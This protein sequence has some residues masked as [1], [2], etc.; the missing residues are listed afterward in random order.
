MDSTKKEKNSFKK[1][2]WLFS[3]GA[4]GHDMVY[5][6]V[7]SYLLTYIQFGFRLS[8]PQYLI[9]SFA[10]GVLGRIWDAI[11]D[12][13]MGWLI[14]KCNF[15]SGKYRFWILLGAVLTGML[16]VFLFNANFEGWTFVIYIVAMNLLW[17]TAY[18]IND[19]SY[20][21]M[22][23]S[24][25]SDSKERNIISTLTL[26]FAGVGGGIIQGLVTIFQTGNILET[27]S[28]LSIISAIAII[29]TQGITALFVK[30]K[31]RNFDEKEEKITIGGMLK[32]IFGNKQLL[33]VALALGLYVIGNGVF[34][35]LLYNIYYIEL[36]YDGQIVI[37]LVVFAIFSTLVQFLYPLLT[38][39]MSRKK[40]LTISSFCSITGYFLFLII[41]WNK[42]LPFNLI[43]ICISGF[44]IYTG[45]GLVNLITIIQI[46]NCVEYNEY[47]TGHRNEAII[48]T[49]RPFVTKM[50]T[51]VKYGLT[52][53]I[54]IVSGV[55]SLSQNISNLEV[56]KN[57]FSKITEYNQLSKFEVQKIYLTAIQY[58]SERLNSIEDEEEYENE[59][60]LINKEL[61]SD[62]LLA[63]FKLEGE[64]I[65]SSSTLY[66]L[67]NGKVMSQ[68]INLDISSMKEENSY[69][70]SISGYY[71]D[72]NGKKVKYNVGDLCFKDISTN[73]ERIA[74]R[75]L[76]TIVPMVCIGLNWLIQF[77]Y[78]KIDEEY[79]EKILKEINS[80]NKL[81]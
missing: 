35:S 74:L 54:L 64:T 61:L 71:T 6:L 68:I 81:V 73:K 20:W 60:D 63:S 80:R 22:F 37:V 15:K 49:V 10:I 65:Q 42:V 28:A 18:T 13:I 31:N 17:E 21:A 9:I 40:I 38:K 33:I 12:P 2:K 30:E 34:V 24:I 57:Y 70:L 14:Q 39:K 48:S 5:S 51:A 75:S 52:S 77:K 7:V 76:S 41:G 29:L 59:I 36:G 66:V 26:F 25:S 58:Y 56:Q 19:I 53:L 4:V 44:L 79:Y 3:F 69:S 23:P 16:T 46:T 67:E 11:T 8:V 43:T 72:E 62:E 47:L 55:F 45:N 78:Y 32:T 27:Y 1:D 50:S